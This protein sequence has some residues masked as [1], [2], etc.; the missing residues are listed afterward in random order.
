MKKITRI[1]SL[2]IL[3]FVLFAVIKT[4]VS[5]STPDAYMIVANP[6]EDSSVEMNIGWHTDTQYTNSY[7]VYTK[8]EDTDWSEQKK[9][10]GTYKLV[11]V[12]KGIYSKSP[13]NE[14]IYEDAVFLDYNATLY[15]L[16]PDTEYMYKVGQNTLSEPQYFKTA[17]N[18][19]FSFAWISDFH[20]YDPIPNRLKSAMNMIG[21]IDEYNKGF[22]FIFSTGDEIAWGGSYSHWLDI[23]GEKY[24]KNYMWASVMGNHDYMDRTSTKNC[25]DFFESVYSYPRNGYE[26]EEG[27]CYYFKYSNVLFITMNNET[28]YG[29]ELVK[30][31]AWFEEVVTKNP[32]QYIVVAQHYQWFNGVSGAANNST[33]YGRWK[34]LFDK[35]GVD[36]A[37]SGNNH[38]YVRSKLLYQDKVST[39]YNYGTTYIQAPSS[40]NERGQAMNDLTNNKNLIA[41]RFSEGGKTVGGLIV[42]VT[43]EGMKI[44]LLDRN[45][46]VEDSTTVKARREVYPMND[47][48]KEDFENSMKY[49]TTTEDNKSIVGFSGKGIGYVD[50]VQIIKDG[51]IVSESRFKKEFDTFMTVENLP[52]DSLVDLEVNIV[53]KD[54]TTK[55][56]D[57]KLNTKKIQ[58][59][60]SNYKVSIVDEGY[61]VEYNNTFNDLDSIELY[62]NGKLVKTLSSSDEMKSSQ[63]IIPSDTKSIFDKIEIVALKDGAEI[64]SKELNYY[65]SVDVNCDGKEDKNDALYLQKLI[66]DNLA[67]DDK[68]VQSY[69]I[70]NDGLLDVADVTY[71]LMYIDGK[72]SEPMKKQ[73]TVTVLNCDGKVIDT[74][75]VK[76]GEN[77][78]LP[79]PTFDGYTFVGWDKDCTYINA[80]TTVRAVYAKN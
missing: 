66:C 73:F 48:S 19:T 38:V 34:D 53:Y 67:K 70:N 15:N 62:L 74:L 55:K 13:A 10:Q 4:N 47:F 8:K 9:V 50:K 18:T 75:L 6:G 35:Y 5:A 12:F 40:D 64:I 28:Q 26:G 14:N 22:D 56:L 36:L 30:A 58:G 41:H 1:L 3:T 23:F 45:G 46:K 68:L 39:D 80:N 71:I 49:I 16:E 20:A 63:I 2:F 32:A 31:Q 59:N 76:A 72:I 11:D 42:N 79:T 77:A 78:V 21:K 60:I 69:D 27:V 29:D 61:K 52:L 25:N 33:G 43:E 54:Q 51:N 37:I 24:H 44:E 17:G 7:V 65:S 57:L